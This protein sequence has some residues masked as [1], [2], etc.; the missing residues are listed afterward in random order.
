L[1]FVFIENE[2]D[3]L[4]SYRSIYKQGYFDWHTSYSR[5]AY[6]D[7]HFFIC[8]HYDI[9]F[10]ITGILWNFKILYS[11]NWDES[12]TMAWTGVLD[13]VLCKL[14]YLICMTCTGKLVCCKTCTGKLVSCKTITGKLVS[15]KT[16]T[17]KLVSCKTCTGKLGFLYAWTGIW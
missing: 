4:T 12:F 7:I 9:R 3:H 14:V 8:L 15:C 6:N 5:L 16:C 10:C 2:S 17:G 11:M 1:N 13:Y